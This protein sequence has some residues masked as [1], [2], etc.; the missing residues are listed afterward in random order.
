METI[1]Q[2]RAS[3]IALSAAVFRRKAPISLPLRRT[4]D[5]AQRGRET[6]EMHDRFHPSVP[7]RDGGVVRIVVR[8]LARRLWRNRAV[9][10]QGGT[11]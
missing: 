10:G 4:D 8:I 6:A 11:P 2:F 5:R 9:A 7:A 3:A 1:T